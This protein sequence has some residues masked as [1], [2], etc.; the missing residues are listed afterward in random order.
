MNDSLL[1]KLTSEVERYEDKDFLKAAMAVCALTAVADNEITLSEHHRIGYALAMVPALR[2]LDAEKAIDILYEYIYALRTH[3]D[4]AAE[5]LRNKVKRMSG[6]Y[7]RSR[8]LMRVCYMVIT[9][10]GKIEDE[11][12]A[13]FSL[14]CGLLDL[15]PQQVWQDLAS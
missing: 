14:L 15:E 4:A 6:D 10:D 2:V 9:A 13:E 8:T 12:R 5:I 3:G 11:E 7:K 1:N